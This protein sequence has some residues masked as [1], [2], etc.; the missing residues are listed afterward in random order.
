VVP[1]F[2]D[3]ALRGEAMTIFG[4]GTHTRSFCFVSDMVDGLYRLMQSD[5]RYPVNLGNP[6]ELTI[7]EFAEEIRRLTKTK[8]PLVYRPLPTDDPKQRQPDISKARRILGWEPQITLED[9]L[10]RT[11]AYFSG[12]QRS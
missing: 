7:K 1:A 4:D 12:L 6:R 5:E 9:G 2:L 3:Q 8:S 10:M 11:I